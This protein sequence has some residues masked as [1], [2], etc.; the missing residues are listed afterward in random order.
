MSDVRMAAGFDANLPE[1]SAPVRIVTFADAQAFVCRWSIRDK[2]RAIKV[3]LRQMAKARSS[4]A[5]DAAITEMKRELAA[6][7]LLLNRICD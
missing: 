3:L 7:G 4:A 1:L 6:R 5:A 2:D